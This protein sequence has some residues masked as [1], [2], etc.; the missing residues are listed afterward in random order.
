MCTYLSIDPKHCHQSLG[1]WDGYI[2]E[3]QVRSELVLNHKVHGWIGDSVWCTESH[4]RTDY[5]EV[6]ETHF[7]KKGKR[8]Q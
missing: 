4:S 2:E 5:I 7:M 1:L 6:N 8:R 3:F